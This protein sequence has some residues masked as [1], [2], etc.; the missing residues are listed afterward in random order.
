MWQNILQSFQQELHKLSNALPF[1]PAWVI[2]AA[3][4]IGAFVVACLLHA[5]ALA[6]LDR[7]LRQRRPYL[8][9]IL[10]ATKNPARAGLLLIALALR[11]RPYRSEPR[12]NCY[13][14]A[15][16]C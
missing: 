15:A 12:A 10:T 5:G 16:S 8:N 6:L 13:S 2:W 4:L 9:R 14:F 7:M 1:A 11:S 3:L